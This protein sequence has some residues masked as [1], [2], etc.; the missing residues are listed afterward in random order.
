MRITHGGA[1]AGNRP[2]ERSN[3]SG[4]CER[5]LYG[6]WHDCGELDARLSAVNC[7]GR[8]LRMSYELELEK[9]QTAAL[10]IDL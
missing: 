9:Q 6:V 2:H 4:Y 1:G 10:V 5:G 7:E 8:L 3:T